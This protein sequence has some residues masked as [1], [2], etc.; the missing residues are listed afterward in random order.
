MKNL[1]GKKIN[2]KTSKHRCWSTIF[3]CLQH[4]LKWGIW[5]TLKDY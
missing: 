1:R 3:C 4:I 2:I 5:M